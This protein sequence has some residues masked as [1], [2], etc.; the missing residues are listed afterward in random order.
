MSK[1][2]NSLLKEAKKMQKMMAEMQEQ[3]AKQ[4]FEGQAGGG[5]VKAK[6]NGEKK[7]LEIKI[8]PDVVDPDDVEMLEDLILSA[9]NQAMDEAEKASN[10]QLSGLTGNLKIPGF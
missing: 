10:N 2:L 9:I 4:T 3:L 8:S 6:V 5:V 1:K 7:L